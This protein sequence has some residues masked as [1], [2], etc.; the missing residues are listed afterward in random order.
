MEEPS[1]LFWKKMSLNIDTS[2]VD[3]IIC[4]Y[5]STT[6]WWL[7]LF[8]NTTNGT[9]S[10]ISQIV[11][12]PLVDGFQFLMEELK[13]VLFKNHEFEYRDLTKPVAFFD[14]SGLLGSQCMEVN[15]C[16]FNWIIPVKV[17]GCQLKPW[18]KNWSSTEY[19]FKYHFE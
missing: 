19:Q 18:W 1:Q 17:R 14:V 8:R 6:F 12:S 10:T 3:T 9:K 13:Q 5:L 15:T 7:C 2:N 4:Q 11:S 16:I